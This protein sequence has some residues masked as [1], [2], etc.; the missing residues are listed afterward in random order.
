MHD[1]MRQNK[2]LEKAKP[3]LGKQP[4]KQTAGSP[5]PVLLDK[6]EEIKIPLI[7]KKTKHRSNLMDD[8]SDLTPRLANPV[9][10]FHRKKSSIED[11]IPCERNGPLRL[12]PQLEMH[13]VLKTKCKQN[14]SQLISINRSTYAVYTP[15]IGSHE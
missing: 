3:A 5:N 4:P 6:D 1:V 8:D 10:M 2:L 11:E 14:R 9:M 7:K 13:M 15:S 12:V